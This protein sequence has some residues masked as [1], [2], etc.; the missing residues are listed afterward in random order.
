MAQCDI[1]GEYFANALQLGP[2]KRRCWQTHCVSVSADFSDTENDTSE[3]DAPSASS[4]PSSPSSPS[5]PTPLHALCARE[6]GLFWGRVEAVDIRSQFTFDRNWTAT[7]VPV[8]RMWGA[9]V[10]QVLSICAVDFWLLFA[11]VRNA[12]AQC[13]N[14]VFHEVYRLLKRQPVTST[15]LGHQWPRSLRLA[16]I[17]FF[18]YYLIATTLYLFLPNSYL[19]PKHH[20]CFQ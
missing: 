17:I 2:H 20:I 12:T 15:P 7:Y 18:Y 6:C 3:T 1:C 10:E 4:G 19:I 9:Y 14:S 8:Q 13:A 16:N 5:S 11:T